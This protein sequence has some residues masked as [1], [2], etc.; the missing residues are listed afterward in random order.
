[1]ASISFIAAVEALR[2]GDCFLSPKVSQIVLSDYPSG[3]TKRKKGLHLTARQK[4]ILRLLAEGK[5]SKEMATVL[6]ISVNT[7]ENHRANIMQLLG[8]Q[9]RGG[10][11]ALRHSQPDHRSLSALD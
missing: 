3:D 7:A 10:L 9:F 11:G 1:M 5:S 4:Q 6:N 2:R 8:C